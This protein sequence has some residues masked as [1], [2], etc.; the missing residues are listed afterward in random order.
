MGPRYRVS[1]RARSQADGGLLKGK[2]AAN[3]ILI[4]FPPSFGERGS[5]GRRAAP[6]EVG[7]NSRTSL[8]NRSCGTS[9]RSRLPV[10]LPCCSP[11]VTR[12][13]AVEQ[14]A[15]ALIAVVGIK[16]LTEEVK[17]LSKKV[18]ALEEGGKAA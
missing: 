2:I 1:P 17:T 12:R 9:L 8:P 15:F 13:C 3:H 10:M 4:Y 18:Q 5:C 7:S 14:L 16:K 11:S 6:G